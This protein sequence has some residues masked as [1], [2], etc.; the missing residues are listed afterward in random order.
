MSAYE[1]ANLSDLRR[2]DG[3]APIRLALGVQAFGINSWTARSSGDEIIPGHDEVPTGHEELYLVM[4]GHATFTVGDDEI[5]GPTGTILFVRD[6]A[7]RR[8]AVAREAETTVVSVGARAGEV[9]TA[10]P[11]ETN[12][13]VFAL[14]DAGKPA[15]AKQLLRE[16]LERYDDRGTLYYNLACAEALLGETDEALAHLGQAIE[17]TPSLAEPARE[18]HDFDS[19][20]DDPRFEEVLG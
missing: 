7:A 5:D 9:F 20:R 13:D 15:E 6:P 18:D 17:A 11:W 12:R 3:W 1:T 8:G 14:L 19:I 4:T 16:A 2:D 10:Q